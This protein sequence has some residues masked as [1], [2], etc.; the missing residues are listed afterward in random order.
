M[1]EQTFIE[2]DATR[3]SH[4]DGTCVM[5]RSEP[6]SIPQVSPESLRTRKTTMKI[7]KFLLSLVALFVPP[8]CGRAIELARQA[9]PLHRA[10]HRGQRHGHRRAH[11]RRADVAQPRPADRD[12]EPAGRGRNARRGAGGEEHARRL[13]AAGA[14]RGPRR[15]RVDLLGAFLRHAQGLRGRH[16]A[17]EPAQRADRG[18]LEGLQDRGRPGAEGPRES[19]SDE[20]RQRRQRKRHAHERRDLP[21]VREVRRA[22]RSLT[23][24]RPRR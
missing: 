16:A 20:L 14:L 8:G 4:D 12:R 11:A 5:I 6:K 17:R 3:D 18:A 19:G 9:D 24:A 13:H 21:P 1:A 22:A 15:Q 7:V 2:T 23:R 10:V